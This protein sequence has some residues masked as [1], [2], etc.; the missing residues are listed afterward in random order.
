MNAER[1]RPSQ[2]G[3]CGTPLLACEPIIL[4]GMPATAQA[5]PTRDRL[6]D[7]KGVTLSIVRCG[8]CDLIQVACEPVPY[9]KDVIRSGGFSSAMKDHRKEQF[10]EF[11]D[12]FNLASSRVAEI[13]CGRGEYL[14]I[15]AECCPSAL[16]IENAHESV[17]H[18]RSRGL[19]VFKGYPDRDTSLPE[20][21]YDA[22]LLLH[23]LEHA[24]D[25][26]GFLTAVHG[27]LASGAVGLV[28][29]PN[30]DMILREG[31]LAEFMTDHLWYFTASTLS[32]TLDLYGFDVLECKATW[33]DYALTATVRKRDPG[34]LDSL[35][36]SATQVGDAI[37]EF[38]GR[39]SPHSVVA[40]GA[41]H[42]ALA[43]MAMHGL[44]SQLAFVVDSAVF[45]QGRF[46]P[47]THLEIRAPEV[48]RSAS[49]VEAV[50]VMTG[51]YSDEVVNLLRQDYPPQLAIAVLEPNGLRMVT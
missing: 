51:S 39:F 27:S 43:T 6:A 26:R 3:L 33:H 47:A 36:G 22:F 20:S 31:L 7:D 50:L 37:Q 40:W 24:P 13:G 12:G 46:T 10:A 48:L 42:Q 14:E 32:R 9:F 45:K 35:K 21:P 17:S 38:L 5:L 28:E 49:D 29:V 16:G 18:C 34:D 25:L 23:F 8:H 30:V 44:G 1:D 19:Q 2:C 15:L 41:G 4:F 11:I